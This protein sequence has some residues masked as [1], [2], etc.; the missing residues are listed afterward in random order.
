MARH[1]TGI[2]IFRAFALLTAASAVACLAGQAIAVPTAADLSEAEALY[3][4]TPQPVVDAMLRLANVGPGD[5]LFD[6]GS[7]DGRIP[8]TAAHRYGARAVG[9][10]LDGR[11]IAEARR[12]AR[13]SG[14]ER[15]VEFRQADVFVADFRA[16]TV[17]TLFL[18]PDMILRLRP[19]LLAELAPGT[20]I[21]SHRFD[22]G[23]WPPER[24][25]DVDGHVIFLWTVPPRGTR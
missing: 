3:L 11:R 17:V 12:N 13:E 7:G 9:I 21:V 10:E 24:R 1:A 8:V 16:A 25:A 5:V 19:R 4:P 23:D 14:V 6:L 20:R 22:L 2:A 18:F 15:L